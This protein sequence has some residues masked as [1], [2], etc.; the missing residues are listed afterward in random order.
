M[1]EWEAIISH[2]SGGNV[3]LLILLLLLKFIIVKLVKDLRDAISDIKKISS[4][5]IAISIKQEVQQKEIDSLKKVVV[6][7]RKQS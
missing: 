6:Y 2:L 5:I 4:E 3:L 7:G 1:A